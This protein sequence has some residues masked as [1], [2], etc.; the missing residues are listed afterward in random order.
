MFLTKEGREVPSEVHE[1]PPETVTVLPSPGVVGEDTGTIE[2]PGVDTT[3]RPT[4][5]LLRLFT[6]GLVTGPTL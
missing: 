6:G 1:P 4:V 5:G 3:L 2:R